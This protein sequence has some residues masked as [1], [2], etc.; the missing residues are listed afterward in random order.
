MINGS[1]YFI[2]RGLDVEPNVPAC[3]AVVAVFL[4]VVLIRFLARRRRARSSSPGETRS[5]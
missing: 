3:V 2:V 4:A 5:P 1:A